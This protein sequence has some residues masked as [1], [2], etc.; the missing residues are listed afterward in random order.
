MLEIVI[1]N[2]RIYRLLRRLARQRV[3]MVLQ[4]GNYWVI[5][6]AVEDNEETDVLLKTCYMRGWVE[7]LQNSVPKGRLQADGS[8]P[9]GPMF[10]SAGPI[11][12]LTDTGWSVIQRRHELGILALFVAIT[13]VVVAFVT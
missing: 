8:S 4:P 9:N 6:Y 10:D 7:P 2:W 12:K 3:G 5:E 11:W 13:G 1:Y